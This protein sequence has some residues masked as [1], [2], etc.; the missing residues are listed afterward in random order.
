MI[1]RATIADAAGSILVSEEYLKG[2]IRVGKLTQ[3]S[4]T[5][6]LSELQE[7]SQAR[8]DELSTHNRIG[9]I[10]RNDPDQ[11]AAAEVARLAADIDFAEASQPTSA[12]P[13][14]HKK[15]AVMSARHSFGLALNHSRDAWGA[16]VVNNT[17]SFAG[18][19]PKL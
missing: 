5:M 16:S 19:G 11:A 13:G 7:F 2:L 3:E 9:W 8:D 17:V 14:S 18:Y 6:S 15:Q 12:E 1:T 4:G 10:S